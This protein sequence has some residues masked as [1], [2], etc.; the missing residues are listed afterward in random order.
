VHGREARELWHGEGRVSREQTREQTSR[1]QGGALRACRGWGRRYE[2][3]KRPSPGSGAALG[4]RCRE[5]GGSSRRGEDASREGR[6]RRHINGGCRRAAG[7]GGDV[8]EA[9]CVDGRGVCAMDGGEE[10]ATWNAVHAGG[11]PTGATVEPMATGVGAVV[12]MEAQGKREAR[13]AMT[14]AGS[15]QRA[16]E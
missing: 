7:V 2:G 10:R 11:S 5:R 4:E 14:A 15:A 13:A 9:S 3:G 1:C 12:P 8:G 16:H 6:Q